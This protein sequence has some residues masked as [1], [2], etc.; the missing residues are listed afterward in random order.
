[1]I[2]RHA[3]SRYGARAASCALMTARRSAVGINVTRYRGRA[4]RERERERAR[5]RA[6]ARAYNAA[7]MRLHSRSRIVTVSI[8]ELV[9]GNQRL[10]WRNEQMV[11][12]GASLPTND[13]WL[14]A[15]TLRVR[16]SKEWLSSSLFPARFSPGDSTLD[17]LTR[18]QSLHF[19]QCF[20]QQSRQRDRCACPGSRYRRNP[21][22]LH[23]DALRKL[24]PRVS[25]RYGIRSSREYRFRV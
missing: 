5:A 3:N 21:N 23:G 19:A 6:R 24:I 1:M 16:L 4:D 9:T 12:R 17:A 11:A 2:R 14:P 8:S 25:R 13:P 10:T 20:A 7:L 15:V 22:C 18:K